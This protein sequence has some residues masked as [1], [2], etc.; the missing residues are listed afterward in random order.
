MA[1]TNVHH[2]T[3][4][5][6]L[7]R[8]A[9]TQTVWPA[10]PPRTSRTQP[11]ASNKRTQ[12]ILIMGIPTWPTPASHPTTGSTPRW[13]ASYAPL[14]ACSAA[15]TSPTKCHPRTT[16]THMYGTPPALAMPCASMHWSAI[17]ATLLPTM[18]WRRGSASPPAGAGSIQSTTPPPLSSILPSASARPTST[19]AESPPAPSATGPAKPAMAPLQLLTVSHATQALTK[20]AAFAV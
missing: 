7:A 6:R 2:A 16:I 12:T 20:T 14:G 10:L 8:A 9:P 1:I 19:S 4:V 3:I 13:P 18:C 17:S 15:F 5:A 11:H